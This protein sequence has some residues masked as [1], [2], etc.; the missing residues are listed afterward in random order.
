MEAHEH[1]GRRLARLGRWA[2]GLALGLFSLA[3]FV[4]LLFLGDNWPRKRAARRMMSAERRV[5]ALLPASTAA[6]ERVRLEHAFD[7]TV[8]AVWTDRLP[9]E[10]ALPLADACL[11]SV[12]DGVL[13]PQEVAA[14]TELAHTLCLRGE[15]TQGR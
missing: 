5:L 10:E 15:A 4:T 8:R 3:V 2:A 9:K 13:S 11:G 1:E 6:S 12:E 7:C 14:I